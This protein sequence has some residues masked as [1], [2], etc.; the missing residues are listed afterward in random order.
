MA[1]DDDGSGYCG[2]VKGFLIRG[3]SLSDRPRLA[4]N[5]GGERTGP[6]REVVEISSDEEDDGSVPVTRKLPFDDVG[7][8]EA[9]GG[10][11]LVVDKKRNSCV[12]KEDNDCVVL[13]SDPDGTVPV[14]EEKGSACFDV[15]LDEL[16]IVAEKG[17]VFV[18]SVLNLQ[19]CSVLY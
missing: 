8:E 6:T 14:G 5:L 4:N 11:D 2:F 19:I 18:P 10:C 13:D 15:S 1:R 16:K 9:T 3:G 17:Q 12:V 7:D